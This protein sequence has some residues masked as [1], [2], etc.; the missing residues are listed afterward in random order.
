M[1]IQCPIIFTNL[2]N[3]IIQEENMTQRFYITE[4]IKNYYKRLINEPFFIR[5]I[6][7]INFKNIN[8]SFIFKNYKYI[9][10]Y[11]ILQIK[12]ANNV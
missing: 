6:S 10:K 11:I 1:T 7:I 8:K 2:I 9:L 3:Q 12:E 4:L 5:N